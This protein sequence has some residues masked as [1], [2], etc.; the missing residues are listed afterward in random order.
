MTKDEALKMAIKA[1]EGLCD[2]FMLGADYKGFE[3]YDNTTDAI[4]ACKK[5]LEQPAWKPISLD[6]MQELHEDFGVKAR[7][8]FAIEDMLKEKNHGQ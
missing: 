7:C 5:A 3:F 6:E 2:T 8:I 4:K 1:M